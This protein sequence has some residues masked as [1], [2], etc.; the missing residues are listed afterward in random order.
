MVLATLLCGTIAAMALL[1]VAAPAQAAPEDPLFTFTPKPPPPIDPPPPN[2][3]YLNGPCG[4]GVDAAGNFYVAD[5]YSDAV[6]VYD[7]DA[8]YVALPLGGATGYVTRLDSPDPLG[9]PCGLALDGAGDLYVSDFHRQVEKFSPSEFPPMPASEAPPTPATSYSSVGVIDSS[10]STGVAAD[11]ATDDV[12][13]NNRTHVSVYDP[14]GSPTGQIGLG[15]LGEGYGVAVSGFAATLGFVYVPDAADDTVK[16]Y[17]PAIDPVNPVATIDGAAAPAGEFTSLRDSAVA[18]DDV[19]GD[20]YVVDNTQPAHAEQPLAIVHVFD[21]TGAYQGHLKHMVVHGVPTGLAVDNSAGATHP[22]GTQGRVYVTSGNTHEGGLYAYPPGA[23]TAGDPLPPAIPPEPLGREQFFPTLPIGDPAAPP[24]GIPCEGDD[25]QVL[26]PDPVDPTLTTRLRGLGNPKVRYRGSVRDCG[27]IARGA[28]GLSRRGRRVARRAKRSRKPRLSRRLRG[29]ATKLRGRARRARRSARRCRRANDSAAGVS[30]AGASS[31]GTGDANASGK[32]AGSP[33]PASP[34]QAEGAARRAGDVAVAD[35]GSASASAAAAG[36]AGTLALLPDGEGFDAAVRAQGGGTATLAGS[37]PYSLDLAVGLDQGSGEAELRD[38]RIDLPSGLLASPAATPLFCLSAEFQAPRTSPFGPSASGESCPENTQVGTVE[39]TTG[40]GGGETVR[41]GLFGLE[42]DGTAM[43]LGAAPFGHPLVFDVSVRAGGGEPFGLSLT[44][45]EVPEALEA[46]AL[47]L[48]LWG[49][50]WDASHNRERGDCLN[51]AEPAFAWSKCSVGEPRSVPP[52]AFLTLPTECGAP[53]AFT[54]RADSWQGAGGFTEQAVN[55]D[56]DGAPAPMAGCESLPSFETFGPTVEGLLPVEK[57]S[58]SS[59]FVFSLAGEDP[60]LADPRARIRSHPERVVVELPTG[61]SLNPSL[62]AGLGV[63][64]PGQLAAETA[65]NPPGAGCPNAAKIGVFSV[66]IPFYDGLLRGGIYLAEPDDPGE[67]GSENPF[68]ALLAV[69]LVAKSADRGILLRIPGELAPDPSDGTLTATFEGLP[70]LPYTDLEVSFRGGQRAPLVSPPTCGEVTTRIELTPSSGEESTVSTTVSEISSGIGFGPCPDGSTPPFD[71]DAVS[72]GVNSNVGSYTPYYVHLSREDEEQEITSY[73][74]T[75]PEGIT[76]K[77]QGIPFCPDSAIAAARGKDG[78]D[79][80]A[81]PSCPA[82]SQVGRTNTGYGVGPALTY[83]PGRI[84]L[85]GP[86]GGRPLSLVTI[87]AATV[88]PFDLGTIVI[89]SAFSVDPR[90]AQLEIDSSASDPIPHI[91]EGVPLHLRDIRIHMDRE[92]FTRNPT[93]CRASELESTLTGSGEEFGDPSDDTSAMVAE[94]FQLLNCLE[95]DFRPRLGLRLLGGVRRSA[96]PA[97]R[98]VLRARDGDASMKRIAVTMPRS[99]FLAQNHIRGIC[100]RPQFAA[101]RCPANSVYGRAVVYSSLFDEPLRGRV[102]LRSSEHRL[103]D[104][105]ASLRSG[106][107][108]IVLEGRIGPSKSG[109]VRTFFEDVPDAP[110]EAF[111]MQLDGGK[112]GLLVNSVNVCN[113]PPRATVKALGQNNRGVVYTTKLRGN[114]KKFEQ[115]QKRRRARQK[116]RRAQRRKRRQRARRSATARVS[117][118]T[119]RGNLRVAVNGKLTPRALPRKGAAPVAVSVSSRIATTDRSQPPPLRRLRI[120]INRHGHLSTA[121]LPVCPYRK[122]RTA[123]SARALRACGDAL[124]GQGSFE[125]NVSLANQEP[126]R[127][128]ARLLIFNGRSK[129]K[130]VLLGQVYSPRPFATAFVIVFDLAKSRRG[131]FGTVLNASLPRAI[132]SWGVVTGI[133]LNLSRRYRHRGKRRSFLSAGC[134]A[135]KGFRV[136]PFQLART[137]F[138]FAGGRTLRSTL[139]RNCRP[140]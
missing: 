115:A 13:V 102:Y 138:R 101:E 128:R 97:L 32:S 132:G 31:T 109:G 7:P 83:A 6:E 45:S 35:A 111:V 67:A 105:V 94:H 64:A 55:R 57:A 114:C 34:T 87:N 81:D 22:L 65:F 38:L 42:P 139:T 48:S 72:G 85:A 98:A 36:G 17:D 127:A 20:V 130:P 75:L 137:S 37:H 103:P 90:T 95:L 108:R 62:G 56:S 122:I 23:A 99:L 134:P 106:E 2:G 93:S 40:A 12:Y 33:F 70:Q 49:A 131:A 4:L 46:R 58:S 61:V 30:R 59:G 84:Y 39:V 123:T 73:S 100:T 96:Y 125:A 89:R 51:E 92:D 9:G 78:F 52:V 28:R 1:L 74:L 25:C 21:F 91:L 68:D 129:G 11:P 8:D 47:E 135:P 19:T 117:E 76:G 77:L 16:V 126:Y 140:R 124:V 104:L 44:A 86:Y 24:G 110:I 113:A 3:G 27:A 116:R 118:V 112:R 14:A 10:R 119:Q 54:A 136:V 60:G 18:I 50:P 43:R 66:R 41:F 88:G 120:E 79:E 29:R 5:H 15:T 69:Y 80:I 133:E 53:L 107:V 121:G 26:P 71:P 63:C 82:A